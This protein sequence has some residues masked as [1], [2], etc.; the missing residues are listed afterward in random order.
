MLPL[1][2]RVPAGLPADIVRRRPDIRE[3]E[4]RLHAA[5]AE[6]GVATAE[7]YPT[8]RL[9]G[10]AGIQALNFGELF[11]LAANT[12]AL[13][14]SITIPIFDGGRLKANL[15]LREASQKEAAIAFQK[16]VLMAW[17]EVDNAL[18]AYQAEQARRDEL[19]KA[20]G[21]SR[22]AL[23]LARSR[24]EQ[25][26]A[27]FLQVLDAQ[28]LLLATQQ[29]HQISATTAAENL[30]ALYKALG[31]GWEPDFPDAPVAAK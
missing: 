25:G 14:P 17:H 4:A 18:T 1:P 10:S 13:G 21:D 29:Q 27:D 23:G 16:T 11:N 5:T 15:R 9:G 12:F 20:V 19:A 30:V 31:G 8:V 3:V 24:Y 7:F 2:A 26:V 6:I 22:R 28:R